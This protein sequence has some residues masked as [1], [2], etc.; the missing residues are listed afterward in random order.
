[1]S[2]EENLALMAA[3]VRENAY[4]PYSGYKVGAAIYAHSPDNGNNYG[5]FMG[6]NVENASY[7]LTECAERVAIFNAVSEGC[8]VVSYMA[9]C[10]ENPGEA[11]SCGACRQVENEFA[12][13]DM[14]IIQCNP[15]GE[16]VDQFLFETLLPRSFGPQQ[17]S[18]ETHSIR[19]PCPKC[20]VPL[21]GAILEDV[22][23]NQWTECENCGE[24]VAVE[25][26]GLKIRTL[27]TLGDR[28]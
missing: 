25:E 20:K 13:N 4:C 23:G 12:S 7:G 3:R 22:Y 5:Y 10:V 18:V 21:T 11:T 8:T 2:L 27:Y 17:L 19:A 1:M 14:I 9:I 24:S 28:E 16:I 26:Y 15:K 6:C